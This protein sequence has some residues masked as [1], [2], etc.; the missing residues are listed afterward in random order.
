MKATKISLINLMTYISFTNHQKWL[1][2]G[3]LKKYLCFIYITICFECKFQNFTLKQ[4]QEC[5]CVGT[6]IQS[7]RQVYH[8]QKMFKTTFFKKAVLKIYD[9]LQTS[10]LLF[11]HNPLYIRNFRTTRSGSL[12][13]QSIERFWMENFLTILGYNDLKFL[14]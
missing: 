11:V 5:K 8:Y 9:M 13:N 2:V 14:K 1:P 6:E 4:N 7:M 3:L 10:K 12:T